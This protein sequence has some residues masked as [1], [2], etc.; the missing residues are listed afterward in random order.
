[1][2][3]HQCGTQLKDGA[4]FCTSC[5]VKMKAEQP[6]DTTPAV[7]IE[8]VKSEQE[9]QLVEE[10]VVSGSYTPVVEE[11]VV[12]KEVVQSAPA[13][14]P[15]PPTPTP[16]PT[17]TPVSAATTRPV[18]DSRD[19]PMTLGGWIGTFLLM[20]IP[21]VNIVL[22]FVWA[23]GNDTNRSKKTYFQAMLIMWLIGFVLSIVFGSAIAILIASFAD[24]MYY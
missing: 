7:T 11:K 22:V 20:L 24:N 16:T 12:Q 2:Y 19:M 5:G 4:L 23:F 14:A 17:P 15:E 3:C 9:E 8:E 13:P 10:T 1:M 21:I 6:E 18:V